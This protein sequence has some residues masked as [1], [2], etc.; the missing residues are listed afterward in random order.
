MSAAGTGVGSIIESDYSWLNCAEQ[1]ILLFCVTVSS[2]DKGTGGRVWS[3][4]FSD[5]DPG[6]LSQMTQDWASTSDISP[7]IRV[8]QTA[9]INRIQN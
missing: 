7:I 5:S 3:G 9:T 4:A 2:S 8:G 1:T 6:L